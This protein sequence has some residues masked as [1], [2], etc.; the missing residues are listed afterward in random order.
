MSKALAPPSEPQ[1]LVLDETLDL[2]QAVDLAKTLTTMRGTDLTIDASGVQ[3]VG[4]QCLQILVSAAASWR[5]D[6]A[7]LSIVGSS[8]DFLEALRLLDLSS[9]LPIEEP[10]Q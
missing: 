1:V 10:C 5:A 9:T 4:T 3:R 2:V 6:G 8:E 7:K